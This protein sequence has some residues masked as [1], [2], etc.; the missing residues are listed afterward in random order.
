VWIFYNYLK[1][2]GIGSKTG[3]E[4]SGESSGIMLNEKNVKTVDLARIGFGQT[5]AVTPIQLISAVCS[6]VN[7]GNKITPTILK[8]QNFK[9]GQKVISQSTSNS[10]NEMMKL[11]VNKTAMYS[12][13]PGYDIGGKTGTAQKYENGTIARGKYI[14]SFIGT[15]PASDPEYVLLF[16]VDE[17]SAVRIMVVLLPHHMVKK[18]LVECLNI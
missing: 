3:I 17:P 4:I 13:V 11:V 16:C 8:Q 7:G 18:F 2:F 5:I 10:I 14:S 15:Y 1:N 9:Q 6:I 12:F